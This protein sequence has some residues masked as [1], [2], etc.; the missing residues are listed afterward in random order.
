MLGPARQRGRNRLPESAHDGKSCTGSSRRQMPS[1]IG[2]ALAGLAVG[3]AVAAPGASP[4]RAAAPML[5]AAIAAAPDLDL[6][7]GIHRMYFHSLGAVFV[8]LLVARVA[9]G[10]GQ[11]RLS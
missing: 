11:W 10:P 6:L 7:L 2:H 9:L 5:C 8:V 3:W 1:P 4:R